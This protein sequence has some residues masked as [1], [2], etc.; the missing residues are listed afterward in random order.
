MLT[1]VSGSWWSGPYDRRGIA[2]ADSRDGTPH[3]FHVLSVDGAR[4]TTRYV[5][6][7]EPETRQMR[8]TLDSQFHGLAFEVARDYRVMQVL[9]SPVSRAAT[10]ATDLAVNVFDGALRARRPRS[11][12]AGARAVAGSLRHGDLRAPPRHV[13]ALGRGGAVLAPL[14]GPPSGD[15]PQGAHRITVEATDEY[16]R[17]HRDGV[18][19]EVS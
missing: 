17:T 15:L 6:A 9:G 1:A 5:P 11:G 12:A 8:I 13:E 14:D 3:G 10:G 2:C 4:Y 19:L 16:G 7:S 18:V